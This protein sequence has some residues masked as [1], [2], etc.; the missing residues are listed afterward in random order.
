[1]LIK[2]GV[3]RNGPRATPNLAILRNRDLPLA[4]RPERVLFFGKSMSRSRCTGG[5][6]DALRRHGTTVRWVNMATLRRWMGREQATRRALAIHARFAP[7]LIF[8][9]CCD[10]PV[11]LLERFRVGTPVVQWVEEPRCT[12]MADYMRR[13]DLVAL[14]N[15]NNA[16]A[17]GEHGVRGTMYQMSGFSPRYHFPIGPRVPR[18]DVAFIGGPGVHGERVEFLA[19]ISEHVETQ[20]FGPGW[21]P[22]RAKYPQLRIGGP[23]KA[24]GF[25]RICASSRIVLGLNQCNDQPGYFSNRTFLTLAC[26][27]FHLT[28]YV[29]GLENVFEDGVHLAWY[30]DA[31]ECVARVGE[32]LGDHKRRESIASAGHKLVVDRHQYFH[33]VE[34][35]LHV[36]THGLAEDAAL[37]FVDRHRTPVAARMPASD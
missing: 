34:R 3:S 17:L 15:P 27:A 25:R 5:L 12:E 8:V 35:I 30:H 16:V 37:A 29:P 22:Y 19:R 26:R 23:V 11:E 31:D 2:N 6:V 24:A 36:L 1:M 4:Q 13:V 21:E 9:F 14:S 33:R 20:I 18:R 10:L 7:D 32:F 28:H